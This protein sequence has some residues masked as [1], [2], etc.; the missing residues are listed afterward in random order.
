MGDHQVGYGGANDRIARHDYICNS[1]F[2]A[3]QSAAL[4]PRREMPSLIS[5]SRSRPADIYLPNW[6]RGKPAGLDVTVISIMQPLTLKGA[7][8]TPGYALGVAEECKMTA[9]AEDSR[10][11][12]VYFG[13]L[14]L[15][16]V[17]GWGWDL[18]EM[19][20]SLGRL[21]AQHLG[22][23]PAEATRHL[24]QKVSISLWRGNAALWTA[25]QP[26]VLAIV[27]GLL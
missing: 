12:G 21:Q 25:W 26:S 9:H 8:F 3:D 2:S 6:S 10:A 11:A 16:M 4:A 23:E 15:E 22:S 18:I 14:V 17:G 13:P 20:K 1:L 5:G 19:V 7:A 24:A 27:D